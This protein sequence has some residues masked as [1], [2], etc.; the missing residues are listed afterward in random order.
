MYKCQNMCMK[1][2]DIYLSKSYILVSSKPSKTQFEF[3]KVWKKLKYN[4]WINKC[5]I[6]IYTHTHTHIY[7]YIYILW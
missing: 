5:L 2:Q 7:I 6:Y 1:T 4:S 3:L